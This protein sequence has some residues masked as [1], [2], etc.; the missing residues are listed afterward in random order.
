[1]LLHIASFYTICSMPNSTFWQR[2]IAVVRGHIGVEMV[3]LHSQSSIFTK[4]CLKVPFTTMVGAKPMEGCNFKR[5]KSPKKQAWQ[6]ASWMVE[7]WELT[8]VG[9]FFTLYEMII[10]LQVEN[11]AKTFAQC[12][13]TSNVWKYDWYYEIL[14]RYLLILHGF[15]L[16][17]AGDVFIYLDPHIPKKSQTSTVSTHNSTPLQKAPSIQKTNTKMI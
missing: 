1:M 9:T 3:T 13:N 7:N 5:G 15:L 12:W 11:L 17:T 4:S 14:W 16:L 10:I 6:V 2:N 8:L